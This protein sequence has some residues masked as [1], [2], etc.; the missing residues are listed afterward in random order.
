MIEAVVFDFGG[1]MTTQVMPERVRSRMEGLGISWQDMLDGY[2]RYRKLLD[3]GFMDLRTMYTLIWADAGVEISE[4]TLASVVESDMASYLDEFRNLD[5]L[6]WMR[7]LK[8][9]GMKIGILTNMPPELAPHF[10]RVFADYVALADAMV[11][12]GEER[13]FKP[14]RRIYELMQR[15]LGVAPE[16]I[17]FIDDVEANCVG[18]RACGW[19]AHRYEGR[20][21][22]IGLLEG[23]GDR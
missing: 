7:D 9:Q 15:R 11:V 4:A 3:G 23:E 2:A 10:R 19:Q 13:M 21:I 18:A 16:R 22:P 5:T 17:C 8:A 14:Q 1:V 12:S 6:E 20:R